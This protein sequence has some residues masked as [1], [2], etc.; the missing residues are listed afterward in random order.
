MS[1][2]SGEPLS[3]DPS[4]VLPHELADFFSAGGRSLM[5]KGGAGTGKTTLALTLVQVLRATKNFLYLSTRE[6]PVLFTRDHPWLEG[7]LGKAK[8]SANPKEAES[9]VKQGF[10]DSRLDEPTQ[11]FERVTSQLMDAS[12]P[13][14]VIDT[15]DA[16]EDFVD[17]KALRTNMRVLQTWCERAGAK[18]IV[19]M[20]NSDSNTLDSIMDGVVTLRQKLVGERRL[21]QIELIKL[22]GVRIGKP[23][24][25][26][27]LEGGRF[28]VF[29]EITQDDLMLLSRAE[30]VAI[31]RTAA[32]HPGV[33]PTGFGQLDEVLGGGLPAGILTALEVDYQVNMKIAFLLLAQIVASFPGDGRMVLGSL[34][35]LDSEYAERYLKILPDHIRRRIVR[36]GAAATGDHGVQDGGPVLSILDTSGLN[37]ETLGTYTELPRSSRGVTIPSRKGAEG[38]GHASLCCRARRKAQGLL[39]SG[40][41]AARLGTPVLAVPRANGRKQERGPGPGNGSAGLVRMSSSGSV[42][43]ARL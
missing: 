26:F 37:S 36:P 18:L 19:T 21:R 9:T 14:I 4:E 41:R 16:L 12:S 6:S 31:P 7:L 17:E 33:V 39:C 13:L 38:K 27:T 34:D 32:A 23:S 35:G 30:Y 3:S 22:Y 29:P 8:K 5:I 20:E 1:G 43:R 11:L 15:L 40:Y 10:V 25:L 42:R 24:H 28:R 2:M